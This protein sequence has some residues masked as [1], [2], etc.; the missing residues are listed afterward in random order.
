MARTVRQLLQ[1]GTSLHPPWPNARPATTPR[2]TAARGGDWHSPVPFA[3]PGGTRCWRCGWRRLR[4]PTGQH[5]RQHRHPHPQ[6]HGH[7][8]R[9]NLA[10]Q[11]GGVWQAPPPVWWETPCMRRLGRSRRCCPIDSRRPQ[12]TEGRLKP[13]TMALG[14]GSTASRAEGE[15][16]NTQPHSHSH[17][18]TQPH[19]PVTQPRM[20][21]REECSSAPAAGIVARTAV[22]AQ[23]CEA[24]RQG[25]CGGRCGARVGKLMTDEPLASRT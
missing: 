12:R 24:G 7:H 22:P 17:T 18:A 5:R 16:R 4:W 21:A 10:A 13:E 15:P 14:C 11:P 20:N 8:R 6:H 1:A 9:M 19:T 3:A 2:R 23:A 25:E